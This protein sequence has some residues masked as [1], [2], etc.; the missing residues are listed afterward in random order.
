MLTLF[1]MNIKTVKTPIVL[2]MD[3]MFKRNRN[4][5]KTTRHK[6]KQNGNG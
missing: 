1:I 4:G 3:R 5:K 6:S 2:I